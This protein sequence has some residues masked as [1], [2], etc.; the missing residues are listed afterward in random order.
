M[1]ILKQQDKW[2]YYK[3]ISGLLILL[4]LISVYIYHMVTKTWLRNIDVKQFAFNYGIFQ[5][6]FI[7]FFTYQSNFIVGVWF[8]LA[9]IWHNKKNSGIL[10][11][12]VRIA[13]TC[14]ITVTML[15]W[16]FFL[17][18]GMF[19]TESSFA[20]SSFIQG[21]FFHIIFPILMITYTLCHIEPLNQTIKQYYKTSFWVYWL[22]PIAYSVLIFVG[23][24]FFSIGYHHEI[25]LNIAFP[26]APFFLTVSNSVLESIANIIVLLILLVFLIFV[27]QV[28]FIFV[29]LFYVVLIN[30]KSKK[31]KTKK[32]ENDIN[33]EGI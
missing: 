10:K 30:K 16:T 11:Q 5:W 33:I 27:I 15:V 2:F 3:L 19:F 31:M 7:S 12:N 9:A 24:I 25:P 8:L 29:N 32:L 23:Y 17:L 21:V 28:F 6:Q 18:P 26:Y 1:K 13:I 14:Y 22:Y 4:S 20:V